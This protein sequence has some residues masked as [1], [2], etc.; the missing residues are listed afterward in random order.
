MR[1]RRW[2]SHYTQTAVVGQRKSSRR[3]QVDGGGSGVYAAMLVRRAQRMFDA[4][5]S[6][7]P[8]WLRLKRSPNAL[9]VASP[10]HAV[11]VFVSLHSRDAFA[12]LVEDLDQAA[13]RGLTQIHQLL[14]RSR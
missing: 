10:Y 7:A 13:V 1:Q 4:A 3:I 2:D 6:V 9:A 8:S 12:S 14:D 11:A 5:A